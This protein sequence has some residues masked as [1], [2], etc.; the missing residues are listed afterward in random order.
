M[1][2]KYSTSMVEAKKRFEDMWLI[3]EEINPQ[4]RE[5][6]V[7]KAI[8]DKCEAY[9]KLY[10]FLVLN[11]GKA[12]TFRNSMLKEE[13]EKVKEKEKEQ[14][15]LMMLKLEEITNSKE[16]SL[17]KLKLDA[18]NAS[19]SSES[20]TPGTSTPISR[21]SPTPAQARDLTHLQ[22]KS[23][24]STEISSLEMQD[25]KQETLAWFKASN[26]IVYDI[27]LQRQ[28]LKQV[29]DDDSWVCGRFTFEP[30]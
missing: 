15:I 12:Q 16:L 28:L 5:S 25:W 27:E 29:I 24:L 14:E 30:S 21:V 6:S 4:N 17:R 11:L 13:Q 1:I 7:V 18:T 3:I 22:P 9:M 2:K 23:V 20:S 19:V 10:K 26:F 8:M